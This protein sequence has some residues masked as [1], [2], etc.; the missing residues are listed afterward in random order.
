MNSGPSTVSCLCE[1]IGTRNQ[2][3]IHTTTLMVKDRALLES[4]P[5]SRQGAIK[6]RPACAA[7]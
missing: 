6:K 2:P 5:K 3:R 7:S 4:Q 1:E